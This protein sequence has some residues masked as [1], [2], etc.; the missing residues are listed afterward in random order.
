[1]GLLVAAAL[2]LEEEVAC[3][4]DAGAGEQMC[5]LA[6][7]EGH[8]RSRLMQNF[9]ATRVVLAAY[10]GSVGVGPGPGALEARLSTA[11][12]TASALQ[13][14][15]LQIMLLFM[16]ESMAYGTGK[17]GRGLGG[18]YMYV[19]GRPQTAEDKEQMSRVQTEDKEQMGKLRAGRTGEVSAST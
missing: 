13:P 3:V 16:A 2:V 11:L 6:R 18:R 4:L 17:N 5:G 19:R 15:L 1:M 7:P 12:T 9:E 14:S 8:N 10:G